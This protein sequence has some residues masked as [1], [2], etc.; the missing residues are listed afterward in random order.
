MRN[1]NQSTVI[2]TMIFQIIKCL[3]DTISPT[4]LLMDYSI[5]R[6]QYLLCYH[7]SL[8][9]ELMF[10]TLQNMMILCPLENIYNTF[11]LSLL[12]LSINLLTI[13]EIGLTTIEIGFLIRMTLLGGTLLSMQIASMKS[14]LL[15]IMWSMK[16]IHLG[17]IPIASLKTC[18]FSSQSSI[19][20]GVLWTSS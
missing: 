2:L 1:Q 3:A 16:P 15:G 19:M 4:I 11:L 10:S 8:W 17:S 9:L 20:W 5:S 7:M 18:V 13:R 14:I 12:I 6:C